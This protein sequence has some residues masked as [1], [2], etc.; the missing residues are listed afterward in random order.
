[1]PLPP[2]T[3]KEVRQNAPAIITV[4]IP[5]DAAL[6]FDDQRMKSTTSNRVFSTPALQPD[7]LYYYTVKAEVERDG[8]RIAT[9]HQVQF[10]AGQQVQIAFD[11]TP[12]GTLTARQD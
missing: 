8:Q 4:Q 9:T 5:A 6:F 11:M 12:T 7:R 3:P 2:P 1:M 10:R